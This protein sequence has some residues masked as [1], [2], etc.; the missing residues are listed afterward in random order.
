MLNLFV[1]PFLVTPCLIV[2]VHPCMECIPIKKKR[3]GAGR[4]FMESEVMGVN[5]CSG[6]LGIAIINFTSQCLFD[7]LFT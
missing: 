3:K 1:H 4:V 2:G 5:I 6:F 7:L